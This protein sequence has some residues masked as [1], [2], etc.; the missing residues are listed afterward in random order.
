MH[1]RY[2][3]LR[4]LPVTSIIAI[5]SLIILV[6]SFTTTAQSGRKQK[7]R[8]ETPPPV[9]DVK[10]APTPK[11][12]EKVDAEFVVGIEQS[13][14]LDLVPLY[15]YSIVLHACAERLDHA[16]SVLV[17][18]S[19]GN[20]SKGQAI[21][22]A[23]AEKRAKVVFLQLR[24]DQG[25]DRNI[26]N[27]SE[28]VVDYMVFAPTTAKLLTS[29]RA[30]QRRGYRTGGVVVG[31]P[32]GGRSPTSMTEYVLKQ[33]GKEVAERILSSLHIGSMEVR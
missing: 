27:S 22:R 3:V 14:G 8:I 2:P 4:I 20:V 5:A 1:C 16:P 25:A 30:Y 26:N 32:G 18:A 29:G 17:S 28:I 11:P 12:E 23:K 33:A 7:S 21:S 31:T 19:E 6:F 10:P 13:G 9:V 15:Y 24:S